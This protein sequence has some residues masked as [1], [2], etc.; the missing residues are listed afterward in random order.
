M[1]VPLFF[2]LLLLLGV[3]V[4]RD[5]GVSWDEANNHLNGLVGLKYVAQVLVPKLA[6]REALNRPWIPDIRQFPDSD[7]GAAFEMAVS[8]L[9]YLFTDGDSRSFYLLRHLSV[10]L[11]FV[12]G[13]WALY[14]LGKLRF[15]DWRLGLLG[16]SLL[17]VSPRMFAEAFYNGKD[18]VYMSLFLLAIYTLARLLQRPTLMRAL[19]HG[20]ATAAA[21][22]T[23][24]QGLQLIIITFAM[25]ALE[26]RFTKQPVKLSGCVLVYLVATV[27]FVVMG[28][29]YLWATSV[30]DLLT[31]IPKMGV[32]PWPM[33]NL[34]FGHL[35]PASRVPWHYTLVWIFITTPLPYSF[36]AAIGFGSWLKEAV[37]TRLNTLHTFSGRLDFLIVLWLLAPIT[38]TI[39]F[40]S[41]LYDGWRHLYFVYPALL[42]LAIRGLLS[43][44]RV[45]KR[46]GQWRRLAL[47]TLV[48]AGS[49]VV[50]TAVCMV[51]MHPH[52][53]AYFSFLPGSVAERLFERDYWGLSYRQGLEWVLANDPAP[54]VPISVPWYITY[55]NNSLIL[56]PEQRARLLYSHRDSAHFRYFI[57]A[58]RWHPQSYGDSVGHEV[59]AIRVGGVKILSV[60]KKN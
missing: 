8:V 2:G 44:G 31:A 30:P 25:L 47:G 43:I 34:Y 27:V 48:L 32:Y 6:A 50:H 11:M 59:H 5:Y 54:Q 9:G 46:Y 41:A 29:P 13:V 49:E 38:F 45:A 26:A 15:Q 55:Y 51:Q 58:Y 36:A 14:Q 17:V 60:F 24:V 7:H 53:N 52:E 20:V 33:T 21:I 3:W 57:T 12:M 22:D 16:A 37:R 56:T 1:G 23:R 42:L 39:V 28:W 10:F 40:K 4:Y 18:I 35:I 19:V